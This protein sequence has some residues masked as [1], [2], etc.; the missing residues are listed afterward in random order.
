MA[1]VFVPGFMLD[2]EMWS[3]LEPELAA[4]GPAH[5]VDLR[6]GTSLEDMADLALEQLPDR[7]ILVGFSLGG[8]VARQIARRVPDKLSA[9]I[10]IATSARADTPEQIQRKQFALQLHD[11]AFKGLSPTAIAPSLHPKRRLDNAL[12]DRIRQMGIRLGA[13]TFRRQ[14]ALARTGDLDQLAAVR[15]PTLVVAARNDDLRSEVEASELAHGIHDATL[16][17][18]ENSGHMI[19]LEQPALL[20]K[21]ITN[22]LRH[23]GIDLPSSKID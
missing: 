8:Y 10:L 13:D 9:L 6:R 14:S 18:I 17:V 1:I 7:F 4:Y 19:P 20:A 22:W 5:H 23:R 21:T 2:S 15:C 12:I 11:S 16:M 3:E